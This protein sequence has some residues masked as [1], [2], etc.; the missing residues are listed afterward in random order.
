MMLFDQLLANGIMI[1]ATYA[2]IAIGLTLIFGMMRIVNF[3]HG[4]F[5]MLGGYVAVTAATALNLGFFLAV[6][7]SMIA[8]AIVGLAFERF[9]LRRLRNA[10]LLSTAIMTIGLSIAMQ[11]IVLQVW[12]PK[13]AQIPDPFSGYIVSVAGVDVTA[14]RLFTLVV[15]VLIISLLAYMLK[16]TK[17]G[18]TLRATFQAREA[19]A[20]QGIDVDRVFSLVFAIGVALAALAGA[21]LSAVFVVSTDMGNMANLKS[22]AVVILGGLGN[23]PGAIF[24]GFLLGIA[25]SLTAGYISTGYKDGISFLILILALLVRPHGLFGKEEVEG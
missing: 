6:P 13:P 7:L 20:L 18:R 17:L 24:G 3:A 2:L 11:N 10:D 25:E 14:L 12:G 8:V 1:G 15:A 21:M 23:I 19:A 22:F 9:L 16:Y 4:E 5:Y